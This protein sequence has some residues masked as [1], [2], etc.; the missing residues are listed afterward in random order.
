VEPGDVVFRRLPLAEEPPGVIQR[1]LGEGR[2]AHH[3]PDHLSS[4]AG[5]GPDARAVIG[6]E[7]DQFALLLRQHES[8]LHRR[9]GRLA[10]QGPH[11]G[12]D[13]LG[14]RDGLLADLAGFQ[15][16]V[17]IAERLEI[18]RAPGAGNE[19]DARAHA[20]IHDHVL[21]LHARA[22][23]LCLEELP[24]GANACLG[25]DRCLSAQFSDVGSDV[26]RR[27]AGKTLER[28]C[29]QQRLRLLDRDEVN[30]RLTDDQQIQIT[31]G[32]G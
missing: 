6:V 5:V 26:R 13:D 23:Q 30:Q 15:A 18:G 16:E 2:V 11:G 8:L 9:A 3:M 19:D 21:S 27:A 4:L 31:A 29:F 1:G 12:V 17:G 25:D 10:R 32:N 24:K 28:R 22:T 20:M 7:G 14:A